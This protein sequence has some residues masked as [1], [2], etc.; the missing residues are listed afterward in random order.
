MG[1]MGCYHIF[2]NIYIPPQTPAFEKGGACGKVIPCLLRSGD[3]GDSGD[4]G[5]SVEN[6]EIP[7]LPIPPFSLN[8]LISL[9]SLALVK[10]LHTRQRNTYYTLVLLGRQLQEEVVYG[11]DTHIVVDYLVV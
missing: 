4:D 11:V 6:R 10:R 9:S 3:D 8:S 1:V 5:Y 2:F 7:K